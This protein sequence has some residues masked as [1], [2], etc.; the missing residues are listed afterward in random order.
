M[1]IIALHNTLCIINWYLLISSPTSQW[2][3]HVKKRISI[4]GERQHKYERLFSLHWPTSSS[5]IWTW[6]IHN[7]VRSAERPCSSYI[8]YPDNLL[9]Y[10]WRTGSVCSYTFGKC[11]P[12]WSA[13]VGTYDPE[14]GDIW[15]F[16]WIPL[17]YPLKIRQ[18]G[19][20]LLLMDCKSFT[21]GFWEK[22]EE[23]REEI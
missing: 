4:V 15:L 14:T 12:G 8:Y 5:W 20:S 21:G 17:Q 9:I 10:V 7:H 2:I 23:E 16:L 19:R 13:I 6:Q 18:R 1:G 22:Q 3:V 11:T